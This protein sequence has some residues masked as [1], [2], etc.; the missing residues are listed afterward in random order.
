[1]PSLSTNVSVVRLL[2]VFVLMVVA[3]IHIIRSAIA[4]HFIAVNPSMA[5]RVW[6]SH[7]RV[8]L[9]LAM[10]EIG[11]SASAGQGASAESLSRATAA[12]VRGPL[13]IEP[14]LIKGAEEL[15]KG[16][17]VAA[18]KLFREARRRD[19]RSAAARFFLAQYY[20]ESGRAVDGLA[21][22]SVLTRLVSGGSTALLPGL[23][24]YA[25]SPGAVPNLRKTFAGN[26][27]L[28][29]QVMAELARDASNADLLLRLAPSN[30]LTDGAE[31]PAWQTQLLRSLIEREEYRKAY[32]LWLRVSGLRSGSKGI[33]NPQFAKLTAP[34]P[35]NW[36]LG[37]D[38]FGVAEPA[39]GGSLRVIYYGRDDGQFASQQLLLEPGTYQLRMKVS[40]EGAA[41][42]TSG[43]SWS[44][45]CLPGNKQLLNVP[46]ADAEARTRALTEQ[47]TVSAECPSQLLVL[48]GTARE[49]AE[50]EQVTISDL[51]LVGSARS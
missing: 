15:S 43:L 34:A 18:E 32:S 51:Q 38:K 33:F 26:P 36:T 3:G 37:S 23:A 48:N 19:P 24:Q 27:G 50:F 7:P 14:F 30:L 17:P 4:Y 11:Q 28:G 35:F 42:G 31:I 1:M 44:L 25:H 29:D 9:A 45:A 40:R 46:F 41:G 13:L 22:A 21:E 12:A 6:P 5:A 47:F 10:A 16:E 8:G 20:L 49:F 2:V 39:D